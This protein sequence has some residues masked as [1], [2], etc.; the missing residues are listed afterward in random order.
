MLGVSQK[1]KKPQFL[2]FDIFSNAEPDCFRPVQSV[3]SPLD[4]QNTR[5]PSKNQSLTGPLVPDQPQIT[6]ISF[7]TFVMVP[8]I[9]ERVPRWSG[10]AMRP[11]NV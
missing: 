2:L 1:A 5:L 6:Q 11:E 8:N 10:I 9:H 3:V 4:H 7:I